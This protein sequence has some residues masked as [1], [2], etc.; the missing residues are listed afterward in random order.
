MRTNIGETRGRIMAEAVSF[1]LAAKVGKEEAH[2]I[3]EEASR[4]AIAAK[5]DLQDVLGEDERVKLNLSVGELARL[6]EPA[7]Y[8]GVAQT[9]ID[10][11]I[12]SL[13]G[14]MIRR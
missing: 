3:L 12:A 10:R 5:S 2:R 4:K 7:V 1:A 8:Q 11:I 14:R 6:F 13:Q 9:L